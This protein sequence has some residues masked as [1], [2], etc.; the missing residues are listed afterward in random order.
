M[1][2]IISNIVNTN[3]VS[4]AIIYP[5]VDKKKRKEITMTVYNDKTGESIAN[6]AIIRGKLMNDFSNLNKKDSDFCGNVI[7]V[8][9]S[10]GAVDEIPIA[11]PKRMAENIIQ[12]EVSITGEWRSKN[13]YRD[14]KMHMK[15]YLLVREIRHEE[16]EDHNEIMLTGFVCKPPEYR[17]TSLGKGV[18]RMVIAVNRP[19]GRGDYI[20]CVTWNQNAR[21]AYN[22]KVGDKISITGRIQ[23]REYMRKIEGV[24]R[25]SVAYE[26]SVEKITKEE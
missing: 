26:V 5:I 9:R 23:S 19:Y 18:G 10:S 7:S 15:H 2:K 12:K 8:K 17:E 16:A 22:L 13:Y 25:V 3:V 20:R 21:R 1:T 4:C 24:E 14:G 11:I 6:L